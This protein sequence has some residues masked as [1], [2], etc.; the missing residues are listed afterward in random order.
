MILKDS[1]REDIIKKISE[2]DKIKAV[3]LNVNSPGGSAVGGE[4][5]YNAIK[6]L[7]EKKPVVTV[8]NSIATSAAY[9]I[10]LGSEHIIAHNGTITGSIGVIMEIPNFKKLSD[11][12]GVDFKY[13]RTSPLKGAPTLF[14]EPNPEAF[15]VLEG[16]MDDFYKFF[17]KIVAE[18]REISENE[19]KLLADGRVFSGLQA[20]RS[21]LVDAIGGEKDAL[22][23]LFTK[24][25]LDKSLKI[26]EVKLYKPESP[27]D[28]I[29]GAISESLS[30]ESF[31]EN[32]FSEKGLYL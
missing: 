6:E 15:D 32:Y 25:K 3:I 2:D 4:T 31:F 7:N 8:F 22:E 20:K 10:S 16:M 17:I 26:R 29:L 23:W 18:E 30:L 12:I 9:M 24:K 27:L 19:A 14:D 11:K 13:V 21:G 1:E 28:K 5:L